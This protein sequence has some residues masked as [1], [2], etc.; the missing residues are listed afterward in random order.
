MKLQFTINKLKDHH[1]NKSFRLLIKLLTILKFYTSNIY[2]NNYNNNGGINNLLHGNNDSDNVVIKFCHDKIYLITCPL[3]DTNDDPNPINTLN[4]KFNIKDFFHDY[5]LSTQRTSN[6]DDLVIIKINLKNFLNILK[7]YDQLI[8][9]K[10]NHYINPNHSRKNII[11]NNNGNNFNDGG[12]VGLRLDDDT[13]NQ[14]V[15][16]ATYANNMS[17]SANGLDFMND[18][19]KLNEVRKQQISSS[20]RVSESYGDLTFKLIKVP[21]SWNVPIENDNH[22][23]SG[24]GSL[25][26]YYSEYVP[27]AVTS[28]AGSSGEKSNGVKRNVHGFKITNNPNDMN[29]NYSGVPDV[30]LP[31]DSTAKLKDKYRVIT[32]NFQI[33]IRMIS[34]N[35]DHKYRFENIN[36]L[37]ADEKS[38]GR[39]YALPILSSMN[40]F[41]ENNSPIKNNNGAVGGDNGDES[42]TRNYGSKFNFFLKRSLRFDTKFGLLL[43]FHVDPDTLNDKFESYRL[44][45]MSQY[46]YH[47]GVK[48]PHEDSCDSAQ[49]KILINDFKKPQESN[50]HIELNWNKPLGCLKLENPENEYETGENIYD[51]FSQSL[52]KKTEEYI[53][54]N[55]NSHLDIS[56]IEDSEYDKSWLV[57]RKERKSFFEN[58]NLN[59]HHK[60]KTQTKL[61]LESKSEFNSENE[62]GNNNE[63]ENSTNEYEQEPKFVGDRILITNNDWKIFQKCYETLSNC[64]MYIHIG[65]MPNGQGKFCLINTVVTIDN[66]KFDSYESG[67]NKDLENSKLMEFHFYING[68]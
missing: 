40:F 9:Y 60:N 36:T 33:P 38:D 42:D 45:T 31:N 41:N 65:K 4:I 51:N 10:N 57:S 55:G 11:N 20:S 62:E 22:N 53:E 28:S 29:N 34:L 39:I 13:G 3:N 27:T 47:T 46:S 32:H 14:L 18:M 56:E 26:V 50:F 68:V 52:N 54:K 15:Y 24:L 2:S 8:S 25:N 43:K 58:D 67:I 49:F 48:M 7:K 35:N 61:Y 6:E 63:I 23:I 66:D 1:S 30:E 59:S 21:K 64:Q 5:K 16:E 12:L 17:E 37:I 44:L 19:L